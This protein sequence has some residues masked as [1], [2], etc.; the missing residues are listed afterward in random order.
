MKYKIYNKLIENE[1]IIAILLFFLPLFYFINPVNVKQMDQSSFVFLFLF[2]LIL[3]SIYLFFGFLI[4][5]IF[6]KKES[7]NFYI[8][9]SLFYFTLFFY[10]EIKIL[11]DAINS[12]LFNS[13]R[14]QKISS[15]YFR[16]ISIFT[17]FFFM[18]LIFYL[19]HKLFFF[20]NIFKTFIMIF[21]FT[22]LLFSFIYV[23]IVFNLRV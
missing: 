10:N 2:Q 14:L 8:I 18:S 1:I 6:I 21:I 11:F 5:K 7:N 20:K 19:N 13:W 17:S 3:C 16:E 15:L 12:T 9:I 22:S 23:I 4:K